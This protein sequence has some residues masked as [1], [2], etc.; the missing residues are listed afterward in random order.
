MS[1]IKLIQ[2]PIPEI[3]LLYTDGNVPLA[4]GYLKAYAIKKG[5]ALP[6]EIEIMPRR[7]LNNAGDA[8]IINWLLDGKTQLIGFTSYMWNIDRNLSLAR[9]IKASNPEITIIMGGPEI[10]REHPILNNPTIDSFVI[11]EGEQAFV[12]LLIDFKKQ[13]NLSE[14]QGEAPLG[15]PITLRVYESKEPMDLKNLPNPYLEKIIEPVPG[16]SIFLETMR[17]CPY[18]C[19]Y[20]FYSKSYSHMRY[21]PEEDLARLF[22]LARE[23]EVEEIYFMDPSF[24]I[25]PKIKDKLIHIKKLNTTNI[26]IH[27]ETRLE[28]ITPEIAQLMKEAGFKSVEAGLQST[29]QKS[30]DAIARSW[31]RGRFIQGAKLLTEAGIDVKTGVILGLPFDGLEHF[32]ETLDFIMQLGLEESMEI[33]PLSLIPGTQLRDE[34]ENYHIKYMPHPPYWVT[35]TP[36]MNES[37]MMQTIEMVEHKIGIEFFPP[38]IPL[39]HNIEAGLIHFLDMKG[40]DMKHLSILQHPET[41]GQSLTLMVDEETPR[42]NLLELGVQLRKENP[43]TLVQIV[44]HQKTIP[45]KEDLQDLIDVFYLEDHYFNH[46]HRFKMD[47]QKRHSLRFFH[48]TESLDTADK[49]LYQPLFC[50]LIVRYTAELLEQGSDILEAKPILLIDSP[51]DTHEETELKRIYEGFESFLIYST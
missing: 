19:K 7:T 2:L 15:S 46:I 35:E 18:P 16:E 43:Y 51:I 13:E 49:Y 50:D 48:I 4:A 29:H 33:Y 10:T 21:F 38:I 1:I 26:S 32:E 12:D 23:Y 34:A 39:F 27:T 14:G 47:T 24:N 41:V 6:E 37:D 45:T 40:E 5:A 28:G 44:L 22:D 9:R 36:Y 20:C 25:T 30:L 42:Q 11:G 31:N 3:H 8:A 17:G